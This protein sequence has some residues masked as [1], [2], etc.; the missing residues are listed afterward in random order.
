MTMG[1]VNK[2]RR[3]GLGLGYRVG[4]KVRASL[5]FFTV[6]SFILIYTNKLTVSYGGP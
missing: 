6:T 3:L 4:V 1:Y 5:S 2:F